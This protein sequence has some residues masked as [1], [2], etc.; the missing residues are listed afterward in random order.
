[1]GARLLDRAR[2]ASLPTRATL[3]QH[4]VLGPD[5][6]HAWFPVAGAI[7]ARDETAVDGGALHWRGSRRTFADSRVIGVNSRRRIAS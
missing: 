4:A 3:R 5:G 6:L 7:R 2:P 1:M